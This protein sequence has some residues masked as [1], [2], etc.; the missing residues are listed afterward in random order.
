MGLLAVIGP[1]M[2][3]YRLPEFWLRSIY[4]LAISFSSHHWSMSRSI[5][6]K[7]T[8]ASTDLNIINSKLTPNKND[9][10]PVPTRKGRAIYRSAVPPLFPLKKGLLKV[11][12]ITVGLRRILLIS[13]SVRSSGVIFNFPMIPSHTIQGSLN[14]G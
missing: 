8:L 5:S 10:W 7:S 4:F 11:A 3:E 6:G 9:K 12:L 1:S 13:F 14:H 2:K